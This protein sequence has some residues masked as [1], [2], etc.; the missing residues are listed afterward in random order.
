MAH[1]VR[2]EQRSVSHDPVHENEHLIDVN[3]EIMPSELTGWLP[4]PRLA[5]GEA[6]R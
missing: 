2:L 4:G 6:K 5:A 1:P 3:F